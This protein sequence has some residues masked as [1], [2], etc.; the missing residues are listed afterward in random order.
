[1]GG[2]AYNS[3]TLFK[4]T[5]QGAFTTL[6]SF[7][8][9]A[10]CAD[11]GNPQTGLVSGADG[12]LYGMTAG[13]GA[14][15]CGTIYKMTPAGKLTTL[16]SFDGT[17]GFCAPECAPMVQAPDGNFYGVAG[18]GG[19]GT[20]PPGGFAG[21]FFRITPSGTYAVLYNFCSLANCADGGFPEALVYAGDRNFYGA[22]LNGGNTSDPA[23]P[24]FG[25]GT[26]FKITPEGVLTTLHVFNGAT[27]GWVDQ[28]LAQATNGIFY[29]ADSA[30][31][32]GG[33]TLLAPGCGTIYALSAGLGPFVE[34]LPT[35]GEVGQAIKI[36]GSNLTGATAVS[37]NGTAAKFK[38]VSKSLIEALVPTCAAT[39]FVT[40]TTPT[41]TLK[42]NVRFRVLP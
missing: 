13:G 35:L 11:G 6:H 12:E 29:G 31:G 39:G 3:G 28:S 21:V 26:I 9:L 5:P 19:T 8:S 27:D 32:T 16:H 20:A 33:C 4:V 40:V 7:C 24:G 15:C 18:G 42:S 34:T 25:C 2:G 30:G 37:F 22:A 41:R 10:N 17:D 23:C 38:V 36:L 14:S 1:M